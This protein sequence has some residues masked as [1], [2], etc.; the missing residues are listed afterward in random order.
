MPN[1]YIP[2]SEQELNEHNEQLEQIERDECEA[3][4][5]DWGSVKSRGL[6]FRDEETH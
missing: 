4:S 1:Y 5:F 3:S 2:D 6:D